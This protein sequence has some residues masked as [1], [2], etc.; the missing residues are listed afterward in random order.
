M[1]TKDLPGKDICFELEAQKQDAVLWWEEEVKQDEFFSEK[2]G[3][4][5]KGKTAAITAV[6]RENVRVPTQVPDDL[7][8]ESPTHW[9][10]G[11]QAQINVH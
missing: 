1:V 2:Q 11:S 10:T 4:E 9:Q 8:N 7:S 6:L 3:R 5:D